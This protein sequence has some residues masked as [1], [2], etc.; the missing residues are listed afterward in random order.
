MF[1]LDAKY[2]PDWPRTA[3][4]FID[5][6]RYLKCEGDD[7]VSD[8]LCNAWEKWSGQMAPRPV[9]IDTDVV[10][11]RECDFISYMDNHIQSRPRTVPTC[12]P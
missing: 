6:W 8:A 5:F 7:W 10:Y 4:R 1:D 12:T 11:S 9:L 3:T 2:D